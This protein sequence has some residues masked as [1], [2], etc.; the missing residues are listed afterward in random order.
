[1]IT[2]RCYLIGADDKIGETLQFDCEHDA[3]ATIRAQQTLAEHPNFAS[4]EIWEGKRCV[5]KMGPAV[6]T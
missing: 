1:M 5:S 6:R 3:D 4:V 2:F